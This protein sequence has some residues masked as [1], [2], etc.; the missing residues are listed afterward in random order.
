[1]IIIKVIG[2]I[3]AICEIVLLCLAIRHIKFPWD[4]YDIELK[5]QDNEEKNSE[6]NKAKAEDK[7]GVRF[8]IGSGI[9]MFLAL[10]TMIIA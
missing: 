5:Y 1:M 4:F 7:R 3:L 6:M 2:L 8:L 9:C 10:F